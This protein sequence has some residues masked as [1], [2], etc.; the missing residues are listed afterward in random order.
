MPAERPLRSN[1]DFMLLWIGEVA[2][3]LGTRTATLAYPLLALALTGSPATAGALGFAR[4]VPWLLFALP[5]GALVDRLN[6]RTIMIVCDAAACV[7][8]ASVAVALAL[9]RLTLGHL[10]VAV[11][12]EGSGFIFL[13][14]AYTGALKQLVPAEQLPDAVAYSSTRESAASLVGPPLG[15]VLYGVAR[16]LPFAV[17]A[18]S[19]LVSLASLLLIRKPFQETRVAQKRSLR[20]EV[21]E[22]LTWLWH[23]PFLRT[24]LLIVGG[25]NFFSNAVVFTLIVVAREEGASPGLIGAMLGILAV[26]GLL[27]A[28]TAPR[29]RRRIGG[30]TIVVGYNWIGVAVVLPL[31]AAS[32]PL[33]LGAIFGV[34]VFFG[35]TWNAVVDGYRISI[36][37]DHLQGRVSSADNVLAFSAIPLAP[38]V[39]GLLLEAVG[40]DA[41]LLALGAFIAILA[42]VGTLSR[43]LRVPLEHVPATRG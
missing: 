2:S 10:F 13:H 15:G 40:G 38:L 1:R 26:G 24:S 31:V 4:T 41:T 33:V 11:F 19:Y 16:A 8:M 22:G 39:S 14:I 32:H 3:E 5:A 28:L 20:A 21:R 25:S 36:T 7:A 30:R 6:R 37:P 29:L 23:Q 35:P 34:M 9:D 27:G 42:T 17:N 43:S 12:V 18:A